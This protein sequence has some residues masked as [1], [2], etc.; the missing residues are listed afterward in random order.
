MHDTPARRSRPARTSTAVAL[1]ALIALFSSAIPGRAA[2]HRGGTIMVTWQASLSTLDPAYTYSVVDW[3]QTHALFDG[4]LGFDQ[5]TK[6]VPDLAASMPAVSNGGRTYTFHL[7]HGLAFSNGDPITAQDVVFSWERELAPGAAS[8]LTYLWYAL[9]G[10]AGYT[11]GKAKHVSGLKVIDPYTLQVTLNQP[12]P[13]FLYVLAIPSGLVVD[14][15]VIHRYHLEHKDMGVHVVGSGP[16]MLKDWVQG[17]KLDLVRNPRYFRA[18]LPYAGAVHEDLGVNASVGLLRLEKGQN[19]LI[20]DGIPAAQFAGVMRNPALARQV[21]QRTDIGVYMIA[22]NLKVKPFN[23]LLVRQAVSYAISKGRAIRAIDGRGVPAHGIIPSSMPGFGGDIPDAYPFNPGKAK[24]LLA[25]AGYP[26]GFSTSMGVPNSVFESRLADAAIYD[27]K[28]VGIKVT[29]KPVIS[30]GTAVAAL[31]M[32]VYHWLM[33]YPDPADFVDGFTP[34]ASAVP[35]GANVGF[36]CNRSV[37]RMAN[38][39]RGMANGPKRVAAYKAIDRK[40]MADAPIVPVFYDV[41]YSIHSK[42]LGNFSIHPI[43]E[44]FDLATY[45]VQ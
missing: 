15:K 1:L 37:D 24:A 11:A 19:D 14:P 38:T 13:G 10:Q 6:L 29:I 39:A 26:H 28:H 40:I 45:W 5:G 2:S 7:R 18:G 4:L 32:Q 3:P 22:M 8:P 27:L 43:W 25:R 23:K 36:Y 30:A 9:Q 17:K 16:Y 41:L 35:G 12:Y 42:R 31:P 34:C 44:P 21:A 20:G 33:D